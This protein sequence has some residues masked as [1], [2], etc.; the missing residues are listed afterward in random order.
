MNPRSFTEF[1]QRVH[2]AGG[3]VAAI[4][5]CLADLRA[6]DRDDP[7]IWISRF[8]DDAILERAAALEAES[9]EKFPLFGLP[10]AVKDNI[11]VAGLP[12][13]A[14]CREYAYQPESNAPVVEAL[15][16]AGAI[17]IG[18]TNLDQF[19][20]GLVGTRS[21]YGIP[22]NACDPSLI[23][24]GSSSGSAVAVARGLVAF[25][26]GTDTAG[27]GRI[28]AAFNEIAGYKPSRG[29]L[30][31]RGVVPACRSLDCVSIFTSDPV[32]LQRVARVTTRYDANDPWS[33]RPEARRVGI[34]KIL[35]VPEAADLEFFGDGQQEQAWHRAVESLRA[36][37]FEIQTVSIA[38]FLEAARLLYEGP[39]V[40][41]RYLVVR[42]LL[43]SNPGALHPVTR[44]IIEKGATPTAAE[45]FAAQ[46]RLAELRRRSESVW[47]RVHAL[48]L[49]TAGTIYRITEVETEPVLLNSNLGRYTNFL[50]LLDLAAVALPAE[51]REDGLPFGIS[52]V[53]P[54]FHDT[55]L[56]NL[57]AL[58]GKALEQSPSRPPSQGSTIGD[59]MVI[60]VCGAHM[61]GLPL[62]KQLR[63]LNAEFL[64]TDRTAPRYR[65]FAL[66]NL[67]P[68]LV[69]TED[70]GAAIEVEVWRMP[71]SHV[72]EF[73]SSIP[74]PLGLGRVELSDGTLTTGFLCEHSATHGKPDISKH[75]GWRAWLTLRPASP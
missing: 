17:C 5:K 49:P 27:S 14:A 1:E 69:R 16:E 59:T 52:L 65:L 12:T 44:S 63:S 74:S 18:K 33:R 11:D 55:S 23:P 61:R 48:C 25:A 41:E 35:G 67:R 56:L 62:E 40:A 15:L 28:P 30:S 75:G 42:E 72:G 66:D 22:R 29:L 43:A 46:Y 45:A 24:G 73:L 2:D 26:L 6:A 32:D 39:W 8:D 9:P 19:A 50:N 38:P 20:T 21:P 13:T 60:V 68:G 51:R 4:G 31:T 54:A 3:L 53:A 7:A 57:A 36:R 64:R 37:G 58:G 71:L 10:F 34:A 47:D 70:E